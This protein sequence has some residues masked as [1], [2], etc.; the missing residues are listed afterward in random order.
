MRLIATRAAAAEADPLSSFDAE[1]PVN[2]APRRIRK[3][4]LQP[5]VWIA[6][7]MSVVAVAAVALG[8]AWRYRVTAGP[9]LVTVTIESTPAGAEVLTGG[10]SRGRTPLALQV[11]PGLQAIEVVYGTD[12]IPVRLT[13]V[14]GSSVTQHVVFGAPRPA[15]VDASLVVTTDPARLKVAVD[16]VPRGVSPVTVTGLTAGAHRVRVTSANGSTEHLVDLK[17]GESHS[18]VLS[19]ARPPAAAVAP[20][21]AAGGWLALASAIPLQLLEGGQVI[22]SSAVARIMLPA[23]SH[24]VEVANDELGFR[25]RRKVQVVAGVVTGV[26]VDLPKAPLSINA[27]PWADV[28]VGAEHLGE[29]PIGNYSVTIGRHEVTFRHPELGERKQTVVVGLKTP[30]RVTMDFRTK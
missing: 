11:R 22:G 24:D 29:T 27:I 2:P 20:S 6:L 21:P 16:D 5:K 19:G 28:T 10:T 1:T 8:V 15:P 25:A 4:P 26:K 18:L 3:G 23:G 9:A 17:A 14:S 7:G 30:A 12:R 13:A